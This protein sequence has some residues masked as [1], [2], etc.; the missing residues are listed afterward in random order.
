M[1]SGRRHGH[2]RA[3]RQTPLQ[4]LKPH[5]TFAFPTDSNHDSSL[6][7]KFGLLIRPLSLANETGNARST[8]IRSFVH[9]EYLGQGVA[10][11]LRI[12]AIS[13]ITSG[14]S[15]QTWPAATSS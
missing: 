13:A 14:I 3:Q 15:R 4:R 12:R 9:L 7:F 10:C 6:Q 2:S 1:E 11:S 8:D 5:V